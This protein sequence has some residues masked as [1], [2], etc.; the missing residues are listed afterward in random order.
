MIPKRTKDT[1]ISADVMRGRI[2]RDRLFKLADEV[3]RRHA[4]GRESLPT[5][6]A[7]ISKREGF[8]QIK[9]QRLVEE[10]NTRA[11]LARYEQ[12]RNLDDRRFS[13]IPAEIETVLLEMGDAAPP[14]I[15]NP[16]WV[17]HTSQGGTMQKTASTHESEPSMI[18]KVHRPLGNTD[19]LAEKI[20][21]EKA[22]ATQMEKTAAY[23]HAQREVE[24]LI[25]KVASACVQTQRMHKS[26]SQLFNTIVDQAGLDMDIAQGISKRAN[27]IQE[28]LKRR[29]AIYPSYM[30]DFKVEATEKVA[31]LMLGNLSLMSKQAATELVEKPKVAP[32]SHA[33]DYDQLLALAKN[34]QAQAEIA[35]ANKPTEVK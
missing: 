25:H 19:H 20:A 29:G 28:E 31:S 12:V 11:Y 30:V 32:S 13:F 8:D 6:I 10:G 26:G 21:Q 3:A 22:A 2:F 1:D 14:K 9:I 17:V 4:S 34:L 15:D 16:N 33:A 27:T 23:K 7:D 35:N 18:G 5:V 24:T